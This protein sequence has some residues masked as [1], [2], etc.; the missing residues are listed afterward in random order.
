MM[1]MTELEK[2]MNELNGQEITLQEI[3]TNTEL[4]IKKLTE[5]LAQGIKLT[6]MRR[7]SHEKLRRYVNS[8]MPLIL[9]TTAPNLP[10]QNKVDKAVKTIQE[11]ERLNEEKSQN[12]EEQKHILENIGKRYT[13]WSDKFM[14]YKIENFT[15]LDQYGVVHHSPIQYLDEFG[16]FHNTPL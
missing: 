13:N 3:K 2:I 6:N 10:L 8:R 11:Y 15:I 12:I 4:E 1:T 9:T 16:R 7:I 5:R 14:D